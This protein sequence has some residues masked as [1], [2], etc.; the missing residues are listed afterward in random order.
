M[1]LRGKTQGILWAGGAAEGINLQKIS[2]RFLPEA[3]LWV[4]EGVGQAYFYH[5]LPAFANRFFLSF[6][7]LN[8]SP[9]A[10]NGTST[11]FISAILES[12]IW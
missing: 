8:S 2:E 11:A 7:P 12:L 1:Y 9:S 5:W 10:E 6:C 4:Q 3:R